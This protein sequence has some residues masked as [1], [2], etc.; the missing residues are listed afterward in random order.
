MRSLAQ[1]AKPSQSDQKDAGSADANAPPKAST[2]SPSQAAN[3]IPKDDEPRAAPQEQHADNQNNQ[4]VSHLWSDLKITDVLVALFT[5]ALA[6]YTYRLWRSTEKLWAS[7]ERQ[8]EQ[9]NKLLAAAQDANNLSKA[10]I[11]SDQRAWIAIDDPRADDDIRFVNGKSVIMFSVRITNIGKTPAHF[12][13]T[14]MDAASGFDTLVET[15]NDCRKIAE[16]AT[17]IT[18]SKTLL[19]GMSYRR[20]WGIDINESGSQIVIP[21]IVGSTSYQTMFDTSKHHTDFNFTPGLKPLHNE[22]YRP[23]PAVGTIS[24]DDIVW[25][26]GPAGVAD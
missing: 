14:K 6:V 8:L 2:E 16:T 13:V 20:G 18:W 9:S 26:T 19:P 22:A 7:G 10:E 21:I 1:T 11:A 5:G 12:I 3:G 23:L 17:E 25:E 24:K 4:W 15:L